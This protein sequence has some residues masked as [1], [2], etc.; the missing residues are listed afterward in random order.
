MELE[1][2]LGRLLERLARQWPQWGEREA[3]YLETLAPTLACDPSRGNDQE[4]EILRLLRDELGPEK[5]RK[6]PAYLAEYRREVKKRAG[7]TPR[8]R[9]ARRRRERKAVLDKARQREADEAARLESMRQRALEQAAER[10]AAREAGERKAQEKVRR[11]EEAR[12]RRDELLKQLRREFERDFL[13]ADLAYRARYTGLTRSD[14]EW[15]KAAFVTEWCERHISF[16]SDRRFRPDR[17]QAAA[18]GAVGAHIRVTARA[19]SGKTQTLVS[20]AIFLQNHCRVAPGEMLLLAFNR[21]A[22]EE[23][24]ER[25][26]HALG[27]ALPHCLDFHQ[28]AYALVHPEEPPLADLPGGRE[29]KSAVL[30]EIVDEHLHQAAFGD[31]IRALMLAHYREDW[32]RV[33]L[34]GYDRSPEEMLA[35]RRSLPRE[36]LDGT[37]YKSRGEKLIGDFLFEHDLDYRYERNFWWGR[38]NYRP[39]FTI[40]GGP[41]QGV[42]IEY[43][44]MAGDPD[45]DKQTRQKREFWRDKV[46]WTFLEFGPEDLFETEREDFYSVLKARLEGAGICCKKLSDEVLWQ[47]VRRRA[48]GRFE[49]AVTAFIGRA[50]KLSLSAD[51]LDARAAIHAPL[52][53]VEREFTDLARAFYRAYLERLELTGED[54]FDGLMQK[55]TKAVLEGQTV[56]DRVSSSGDL[57][58][59]RFV[60]IDEYQD[61]SDLFHRLMEAIRKKNPS[62]EFFCV[63]DDWQ[64]I[65]GFAGSDLRFFNE[66]HS[67]FHPAKSLTIPTN[68][69]SARALVELSNALMT[70]RGTPAKGH[71]VSPGQVLTADL[72]AFTPNAAEAHAFPGEVITPAVLRL[73][74]KELAEG[75]KVALLARRHRL[76]WYVNLPRRSS[77]DSLLEP[78]LARLLEALPKE[79]RENVTI[80]TVHGFKGSQQDTVI[81]LDGKAR[82]YPLV[83]PDWVFARIFGEELTDVMDAER[84]LFYVALT[85]AVDRLLILTEATDPAPLLSEVDSRAARLDWAVY[86]PLEHDPELVEVRVANQQGRGV[87][88]TM[89]IKDLLRRDDYDWLRGP[90]VWSK[91]QPLQGFSAEVLL[92]SAPWTSKADGVEIRIHQGAE[93]PAAIYRLDA[94]CV[95]CVFDELRTN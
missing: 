70:D 7:E 54:D 12:L 5:F 77:A 64:A 71:Q 45:Y 33:V 62:V 27:S 81:V 69:R 86:P 74:R 88:P 41:Q 58:Q 19:G 18:I 20:R 67:I 8:Q 40:L 76:P 11:E 80:S 51:S 93:R 84:R 31:R 35:F 56:F 94:G 42:V 25:L 90:R 21:R 59:L 38:I 39:D 15:A 49:K 46:E 53:R 48:I 55:A 83:H 9:G 75:R 44:G 17:E 52:S 4:R 68:Y 29:R 82:S 57:K 24:H 61:F 1:S 89:S 60:L 10:E 72:L 14:Y 73:V 26:A 13:S 28:L 95:S 16:Q 85:R 87:S 3:Y 47:R 43:F 30:Q 50:R 92:Q 32:E 66:F 6:L 79:Q 34:G 36:G 78:F 91:M 65:N 22:A 63:G 37:P 23:M 2:R